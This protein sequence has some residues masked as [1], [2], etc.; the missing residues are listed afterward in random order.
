MPKSEHSERKS[1]IYKS[2]LWSNML[3]TVNSIKQRIQLINNLST[4][5]ICVPW[6]DISFGATEIQ[7]R[8]SRLHKIPH[9]SDTKDLERFMPVVEAL[10]AFK[11]FGFIHGDLNKKNI[12]NTPSGFYIVDL[13]PSL[14]QKRNDRNSLIGTAPYIA[15]DDAESNELTYKT[16]K[17][18]FYFF[19]LRVNRWV[20]SEI[21]VGLVNGEVEIESYL[22]VTESELVNSSYLEILN[23]AFSHY[24]TL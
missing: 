19:I 8:Q 16:D 17:L 20:S 18:S 5:P 12:I 13:E 4:M 21:I 7:Y 22:P 9:T 24:R 23:I 3:D 10:N 6:T 1:T 14:K 15:S 11:Q 2:Y